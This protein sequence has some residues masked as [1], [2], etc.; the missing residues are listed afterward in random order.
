MVFQ[1]PGHG[2]RLARI[3]HHRGPVNA[4]AINY[5]QDVLVSGIVKWLQSSRHYTL[6]IRSTDA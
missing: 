4:L 2:E 6:R 5:R 3:D 1:W